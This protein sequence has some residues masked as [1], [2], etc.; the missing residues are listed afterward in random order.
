MSNPFDLLAARL[1]SIEA[2]LLDIKHGNHSPSPLP[3]LPEIG[4]IAL[5]EEITGLARQTIYQLVSARRIPH[6][7]NA[8]GKRLYFSR[9]ELLD[10]I[11]SGKRLT[12]Q[13]VDAERDSFL[14]R[15]QKA[16]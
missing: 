9:T 11:E 2:L 15:K 16:I 12:D 6:R 3:Q 14:G 10:W 1:D 4:T 13:E 8:N 5:A 7:K